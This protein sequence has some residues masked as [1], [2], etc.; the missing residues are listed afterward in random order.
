MFQI[1]FNPLR[2]GGNRSSYIPKGAGLFKSVWPSGTT[3]RLKGHGA[4]PHL[5]SLKITPLKSGL[6]LGLKKNEKGSRIP[7]CTSKEAALMYYK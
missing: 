1:V 6:N 7:R 5:S 3:S 2:S 4:F